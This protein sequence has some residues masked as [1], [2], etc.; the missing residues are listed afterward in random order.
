MSSDTLVAAST[1]PIVLSLLLSGESYGYQI[2]QRV[3][4]VSGGTMKWSSAMLYPVLRRMEKEGL[5]RSEWRVSDE[6]RMRKY[7]TLTDLGR[8]E[9]ETE[10]ALWINIEKALTVIWATAGAAD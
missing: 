1:K 9:F 8:K 3:R 2:L 5:I 4:R 7:Y 6:K 10:K